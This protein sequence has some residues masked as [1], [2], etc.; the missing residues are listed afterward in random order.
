MKRPSIIKLMAVLLGFSVIATVTST[1]AWFA[2]TA[3]IENNKTPIEGATE[4]AYFAYGDGSAEKPYGI[5][6]P[7][8]LYNLAWLNYLGF[9]NKSQF[10]FEKYLRWA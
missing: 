3:V 5:K 7:R 1:I 9:F 6:K 8:H 10:Y 4:G 2:P